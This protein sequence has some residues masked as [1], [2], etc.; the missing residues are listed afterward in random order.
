MEKSFRELLRASFKS[1]DTEE[2]LDVHFT[3]PIG[4]AFALVWKRLGV[5]PNAVTILSFFLGAGAGWMFWHDDLVHNIGGV[6]LLML[7]NFCDSTDGQ[8]ARITGQKTLLGRILDGFSSDVWFVAI[9]FALAFRLAGRDIPFTNVHWG[10]GIFIV[11]AFAGLVCHAR[12]CALADYYRQI[13]L[14]FLLGKDGS[15]LADSKE[16]WAVYRSIP[17]RPANWF[18]L[19]YHYNYAKYCAGQARRTPAFQRFFAKVKAKWPAEGTIPQ[20]LRDDFRRGSKP[21][22]KYTNILTF[23]TRA[24]VLYLSCL[25]DVPY[26]Y[27]LFEIVVMSALCHHMWSRHEALCSQLEAKHGL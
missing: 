10:I 7:A 15:E 20:T 4:L 22:M 8:L 17:R 26:V 21:L 2:W 3:R 13:H 27:P 14:Y 18:L 9:Y 25:F 23:N 6:V 5:H 19:V 24:I 1:E 12:Q 11:C 16:Q